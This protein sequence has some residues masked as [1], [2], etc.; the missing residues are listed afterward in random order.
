MFE[1]SLVYIHYL[2]LCRLHSKLCNNYQFRIIP[3]NFDFI[4]W[5]I[6]MFTKIK[7]DLSISSDNNNFVLIV[8]LQNH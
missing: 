5:S 7:V 3:S 1:N 2:H 6:E 8:V 4:S